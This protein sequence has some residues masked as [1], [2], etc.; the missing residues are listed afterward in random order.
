MRAEETGEEAGKGSKCEALKSIGC[1][2]S[3]NQELLQQA[4]KQEA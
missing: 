4:G 1:P 2:G 3:G